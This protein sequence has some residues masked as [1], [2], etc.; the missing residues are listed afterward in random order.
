MERAATRCLRL[1]S[2]DAE[3]RPD[4]VM[5]GFR[6]GDSFAILASKDLLNSVFDTDVTELQVWGQAHATRRPDVKYTLGVEM[7]KYVL[8]VG[9]SYGDCLRDLFENWSPEPDDTPAL[10]PARHAIEG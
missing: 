4:W 9:P 1:A 10:R 7:T 5:V 8:I 2:M 3:T 6:E